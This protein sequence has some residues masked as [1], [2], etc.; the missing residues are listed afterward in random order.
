[1]EIG[2]QAFSAFNAANIVSEAPPVPS[3]LTPPASILCNP[4]LTGSSTG[5]RPSIGGSANNCLDT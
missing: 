2:Q 1:M 5:T 4:M 3:V